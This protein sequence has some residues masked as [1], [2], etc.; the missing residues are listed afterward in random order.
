MKHTLFILA[1]AFSFHSYAQMNVASIVN[2]PEHAPTVYQLRSLQS[3]SDV[4]SASVIWYENFREGLDGNNSSADPSWSTS[5]EDGNIWELDF[6]GSNGDYAGTTPF[7]LESES[8]DNGWMIFDADGANAGLPVSQYSERKGQLTSP[9]IDLSNDSNVTLSFEHGYRWCCNNSHELVVS[10]NDGSGWDNAITYQVNDLGDVNVLS[11]TLK[12]EIIITETA[13]LKDSVQI[14]FDWAIDAETASHYF[15]MVDDVKI[16]ETQPYASNIL[17]SYNRVPSTYF[18]GTSYRIIP[19]EQISSNAYFFGGIVENVGF[20]TLDSMRVMAEVNAEGFSTESYGVSI[21]SASKDTLFVNEGFT[22]TNTGQY[23]ASILAKDDYDNTITDTLTQSFSVS[24]FIYARDNGDN[25]TNFGRFGINSDGSRQYGNIFD[26]F[27]T[28]TLYSIRFRLDE[29]TTPNAQG[30]VRVNSV[31]PTSGEVSYLTETETIN[32]GE[33]T[34]EWIDVSFDPPLILDAGQV[35]LPTLFATYNGTDT[36]FI[37][38]AGNNP[39]N[40]ESLVQDIDGIQEGVN[41]GTWLYTTT[42]PCLRLN[43]DP[44]I[45]GVNVGINEN[46]TLSKFII[47]PNPN[48]GQFNI[49]IKTSE[50]EELNVVIRNVVGQTVY[51]DKVSVI[52]SLNKSLDLSHFKKGIYTI[53]LEDNSSIFTTKKITIQ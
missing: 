39:N 42:A 22:P 30:T 6:D 51:S 50:K 46:E 45:V 34:G 43:F 17:T 33:F 40:G 8:A 48:N 25:T 31:D 19:L 52:N 36:V 4:D 18:G 13:A 16:S 28:S 21:P 41:P 9:Y 7:L 53:S 37:S 14:R 11:G 23:T 15:W 47:F 3:A 49:Q 1:M 20:N 26:I 5:G 38:T 2:V 35:I 27:T 24:E 10:I 44:S 29:T 32:F 12:V